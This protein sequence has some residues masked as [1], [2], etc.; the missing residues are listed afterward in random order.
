MIPYIP[1]ELILISNGYLFEYANVDSV[2]TDG[3]PVVR[4]K[5]NS[6]L[7]GHNKTEHLL[8]HPLVLQDVG[9]QQLPNG[10]CWNSYSPSFFMYDANKVGTQWPRFRHEEVRLERDVDMFNGGNHQAKIAAYNDFRQFL[11]ESIFHQDD[12]KYYIAEYLVEEYNATGSKV[13]LEEAKSLYEDLLRNNSD[14]TGYI[15]R[16]AEVRKYLNAY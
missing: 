3:S 6:T 16:L 9:M 2:A 1:G 13:S 5:N 10:I 12:C 14:H 4:Y 7:G 11:S 8:V 15:K